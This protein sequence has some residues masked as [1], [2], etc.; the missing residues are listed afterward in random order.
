[1]LI[2]TLESRELMSVT[3]A[4]PSPVPIPYPV[5]AESEAAAKKKPAPKLT[6]STT[7]FNHAYG[8]ISPR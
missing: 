7:T 1:M 5:V 8:R 3:P 2:E 6:A 4:A